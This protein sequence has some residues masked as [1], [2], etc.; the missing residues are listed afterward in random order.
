MGVL[1]G[2]YIGF[3]FNGTHSS[4]LGIIRVS[5]GA[6]Y[7][8]ELLPSIEDK[9]VPV[10]GGDGVYYFGSEYRS[11]NFHISIAFDSLTETQ[12]ANLQS[13]FG[14]RKIHPL[15]FDER[16][17]KV[18]NVKVS[19]P[20]QIDYIAF[21]SIDGT[22]IYKGE[23]SIEFQATSPFARSRFKY[24][25]DYTKEKISEWDTELGNLNEWLAASRIQAKGARDTFA[26]NSFLIYN[27]GDLPTHY[28]LLLPFT[29]E[30]AI[31]GGTLSIADR[32]TD[33]LTWSTISRQGDDWGV[34]INTKLNLFEGIT[35]S[36]TLT[37]NLYNRN[38]IGGNFFLLPTGNS[39]LNVPAAAVTSPAPTINYDYIYF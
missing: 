23:G 4:E 31:G 24:L 27:A 1:K 12:F 22:R 38:K 28:T 21:D 39:T 35:S 6:R 15:I 7:Q 32:P 16:P 20:P 36:N 29:V 19:L 2:D 10:P 30:G 11:R 17:Y 33:Q 3:T 26:S 5:E 9:I 34:R 37:G 25:G 18:Y 14:D 8:E 13:L